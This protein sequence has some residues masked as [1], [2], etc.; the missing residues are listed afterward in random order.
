MKKSSKG[1]EYPDRL[2]QAFV[3]AELYLDAA[4]VQA[5]LDL[6]V[7]AAS[8]SPDDWR[9]A[10]D[11][12]GDLSVR[13]KVAGIVWKDWFGH[14]PASNGWQHLA[15]HGVV[16]LPDRDADPEKVCQAL[17]GI[18]YAR[19]LA[20]RRSKSARPLGDGATSRDDGKD[21]YVSK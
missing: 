12:I 20:I 11:G 9:A 6:M 19:H 5:D 17:I 13:V 10:I 8:R 1:F 18:G 14:R 3:D 15:D 2:T 16:S 7:A 4:T 21:I